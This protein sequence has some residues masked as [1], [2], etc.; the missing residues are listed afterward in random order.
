MFFWTPYTFV[1]IVLFFI[2]GI[3]TGIYHPDWIPENIALSLF[4]GL[5]LIYFLLYVLKKK[6]INPGYIG[7]PVIVLA[8]YLNTLS[9]TDYRNPQHFAFRQQS[10]TQYKVVITGHAEEKEK[11]WKTDAAVL[12]FYDGRS[13][14]ESTGK[15]LLYFSRQDFTT[16]F[17]YGDELLIAGHPNP[18]NKPAN[19]GEFDYKRFL[20]FRKIYHQHFLRQRDVRL[21]SNNPP[22][23]IIDYSIRARVWAEG[24]LK[25]HIHGKKERAVAFA[26]ILGVKDGLDNDLVHAYSSTGAMHVLAVSGLHV[27]IIYMI[28][29]FLFIPLRNRKYG[30]VILA[31]A[32]VFLLWSYAFITGLSPSVLR[33]V[34]MFTFLAISRPLNY[35]T[36]IF[37]TLAVS[38]FCLLLWEPFF[39]MS[40][41][42]QLSYLAVLGIV[43]LQPK[44][45]QLWI[46]KNLAIDKIWQV[47]CVSVAAQMA[48]F[49]LG[50]L[51]FH[52]FP[53]Y[54]L[55]SNLFV[56]P[57]ALISLSLGLALLASSAIAPLA[58]VV[59]VVLESTLSL[60]NYLVFA[61]ERLPYSLI[62]NIYITT[63]QSWLLLAL[64]TSL[65]LLIQYR[66]FAYVVLFSLCGVWFG[67]IQWHHRTSMSANQVFVV[68]Q[69][70]GHTAMEWMA[71]GNAYFFTDSIL[72]GNRDRIRFH[73]RPNRLLNGISKIHP[74]DGTF[75]TPVKGGTLFRWNTTTVFQVTERDF[76]FP[77][78]IEVDY[79]VISNNAVPDLNHLQPAKL[80][81][82]IVDS[83]NSMYTA[84]KILREAGERGIAV[85]S[86]LH[87]GAFVSKI[88]S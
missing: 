58:E 35:S 65:V 4:T 44:L 30:K 6:I 62:D 79:L 56:I 80:K 17:H 27:G 63:T 29:N 66:S 54:F 21:V 3:L 48:T 24:V 68:Y 26:L 1:R 25:K 73:I 57:G 33:A 40:V 81:A 28:I 2:A 78:G 15:I 52:Q 47:T 50:I 42:F 12:A 9:K 61:V 43:Y 59:G 88:V 49:A 60:M 32:G 22:W 77:R 87:R 20:S 13:W 7:I 18:L 67:A 71:R 51:Y 76:F 55:V 5:I 23:A 8:G 84:I 74:V 72:M 34:T 38:A 14:I 46:P 37:N 41:G 11:S 75:S 82:V 10:I 85:H 69:V 19:P 36:N 39:I 70:N 45:Y 31:V 86:V 53:V 16:P 83:S 64:V